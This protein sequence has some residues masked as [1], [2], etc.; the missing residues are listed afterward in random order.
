[1]NRRD[2]YDFM[3]INSLIGFLNTWNF[4][5][6]SPNLLM[7]PKRYSSF[8][9]TLWKSIFELLTNTK[10]NI[11]ICRTQKVIKFGKKIVFALEYSLAIYHY[12]CCSGPKSFRK[13]EWFAGSG[14]WIHCR[15]SML[16]SLDL[17]NIWKIWFRV[18]VFITS[19]TVRQITGCL[20]VP[21]L[22]P[23]NQPFRVNFNYVICA[24]SGT[25]WG[26]NL[27]NYVSDRDST[28]IW[29]HRLAEI[30]R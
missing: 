19:F 28:D 24:A 27:A 18:S 11:C 9:Y 6:L 12:A 21:Y 5:I 26:I 10:W 15:I 25:Y 17:Q 20:S 8:L 7:S 3:S 4:F 22:K 2:L 30:P 16:L 23:I 13:P 29:S 14:L 1:M